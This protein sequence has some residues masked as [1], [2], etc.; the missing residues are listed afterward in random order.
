MK[1][2][3]ID[4]SCNWYH[5]SGLRQIFFAVLLRQ[6]FTSSWLLN[7]NGNLVFLLLT[8]SSLYSS[9]QQIINHSPCIS[10]YN[11]L[12]RFCWYPDKLALSIK[13]IMH[14]SKHNINYL[15]QLILHTRSIQVFLL[16]F[17]RSSFDFS[18]LFMLFTL[19]GTH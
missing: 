12:S 16:E 15:L 7:S 6:I 8:N 2:T 4:F 10:K 13:L 5:E 14:I 1:K 17:H 18:Q 3:C 11:I 19:K 9:T